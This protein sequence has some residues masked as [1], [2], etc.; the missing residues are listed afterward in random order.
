MN[1]QNLIEQEL[2]KNADKVSLH[3]IK[4]RFASAISY[5]NAA[6]GLL[7]SPAPKGEFNRVI[8]TNIYN[9][10]RIS[11]EVLLLLKGFK[12]T[13]NNHHKTVLLVSKLL[14]DDEKM[15]PVF[16]RLDRMRKNRNAIDYDLDALDV[17]DQAIKQAMAD[18]QVFA[19]KVESFIEQKDDQQKMKY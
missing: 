2:L 3:Q 19:D 18:A 10:I 12:A 11:A 7:N 1:L 4:S 16:S 6:K 17:S 5:L 8:Y 15:D 9:A 14:M 13:I